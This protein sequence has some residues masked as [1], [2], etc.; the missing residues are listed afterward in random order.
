MNFEV[1][2]LVGTLIIQIV[3]VAY[4]YGKL[5]EKVAVNMQQSMEHAKILEKHRTRL[6]G[7][8]VKLSEVNAW[9][10]GYDAG[11]ATAKLHSR[12]EIV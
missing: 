8:D 3:G 11:V 1:S 7:I 4:V 6:D 10:Q 9:R 2:M 5:S 12:G